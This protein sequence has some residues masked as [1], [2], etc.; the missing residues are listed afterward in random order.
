MIVF[1]VHKKYKKINIKAIFQVSIN[2]DKYV[3]MY[4]TSKSKMRIKR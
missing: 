1:N 4:V 2:N 3:I